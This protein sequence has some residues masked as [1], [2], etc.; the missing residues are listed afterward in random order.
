MTVVAQSAQPPRKNSQR[1]RESSHAK[2]HH[3]IMTELRIQRPFLGS[4]TL[5]SDTCL[6]NRPWLTHGDSL[7]GERRLV[8]VLPSS[9][10]RLSCRQLP[11][12]ERSARRGLKL[13]RPRQ[14]V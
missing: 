10:H 12:G 6:V 3:P 4:T 7:A 1:S 14:F 13:T 2:G 8:C 5:R 11:P 9:A